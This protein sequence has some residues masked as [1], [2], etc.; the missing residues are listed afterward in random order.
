ML[1]VFIALYNTYS[2]YVILQPVCFGQYELMKSTLKT[3]R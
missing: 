3:N 2:K 1:Y